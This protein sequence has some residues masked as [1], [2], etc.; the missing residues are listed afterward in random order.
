MANFL[1]SKQTHVFV[2]IT[3]GIVL[4]DQIT[5][6]LIFKYQP[7]WQL[8][9]FNISFVKN[10]GAGFG[11][12]QGYPFFLGIISLIIVGIIIYFYPKIPKGWFPQ[13]MLAMFLGGTIGNMFDRLFRSYVIDFIGTTFWPS[14]NLADAMISI[15]AVGLVIYLVREEIM[16][17]IIKSKQ[18]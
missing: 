7:N 17:R 6:F 9:I 16:L 1:Q 4:L 2:L 10:T 11:I 18:K 12:L 3:I 8:A 15:A 5:K 14:F 13:I